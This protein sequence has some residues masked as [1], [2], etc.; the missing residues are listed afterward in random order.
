VGGGNGFPSVDPLTLFQ[1][2]VRARWLA[3]QLN[4]FAKLHE[5]MP[6]G[7]ARRTLVAR[8]DCITKAWCAFHALHL[9]RH[10]RLVLIAAVDTT[11][12]AAHALASG[13]DP[14][15]HIQTHLFT[16]GMLGP[17]IHQFDLGSKVGQCSLA[18]ALYGVA[19]P[20]IALK[21]NF[22]KLWLALRTWKNPP[23]NRAAQGRIS[24]W[25]A[26]SDLAVSG[27]LHEITPRNIEREWGK[28][29]HEVRGDFRR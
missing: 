27:G 5:T 11:V 18:F 19:F 6:E 15:D 10:K 16:I 24:K 17:A 14:A 29:R 23:G 2:G 8:T 22:D 26:I 1:P 3:R 28:Y 21:L 12:T 25:K 13:Q 7:E 9:E 4:F 20:H